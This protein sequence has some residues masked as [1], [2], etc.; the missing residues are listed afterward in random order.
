MT[1]PEVPQ[2]ELTEA[3]LMYQIRAGDKPVPFVYGG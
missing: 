3:P 1:G 2:A